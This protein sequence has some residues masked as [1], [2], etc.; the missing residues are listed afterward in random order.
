[1]HESI[2]GIARKV[3]ILYAHYIRN[4]RFQLIYEKACSIMKYTVKILQSFVHVIPGEPLLI[5]GEP[6]DIMAP[7][8]KFNY[9]AGQLHRFTKKKLAQEFVKHWGSDKVELLAE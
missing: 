3:L 4:I 2:K 6:S 7:E 9:E 8:F 5:N 1:M